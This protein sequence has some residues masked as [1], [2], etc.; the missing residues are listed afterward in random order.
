MTFPN[1]VGLTVPA[2]QDTYSG[3]GFTGSGYAEYSGGHTGLVTAQSPAAST[4]QPADTNVTL[5]VAS[6]SGSA[7]IWGS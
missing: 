7:V 4:D 5:T 3:A 2:A 1:L 6:P